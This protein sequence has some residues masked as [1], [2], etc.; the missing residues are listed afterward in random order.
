MKH[1]DDTWKIHEEKGL[2]ALEE[3]RLLFNAGYYDGASMRA[4][5]SCIQ[6]AKS[7]TVRH[8]RHDD[9]TEWLGALRTMMKDGYLPPEMRKPLSEIM[10]THDLDLTASHVRDAKHAGEMIDLTETFHRLVT[11]ASALLASINSPAVKKAAKAKGI[12][13]PAPPFAV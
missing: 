10:K 5:C 9:P 11:S 8:R 1:H 7:L 13:L 12:S 2:A 6:M 4:A 3:A